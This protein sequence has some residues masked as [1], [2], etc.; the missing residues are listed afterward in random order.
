[1]KLLNRG[2]RWATRLVLGGLATAMLVTLWGAIPLLREPLAGVA[3]GSGH[4]YSY[5]TSWRSD[6]TSEP[7]PSLFFDCTFPLEGQ[8]LHLRL[9][10][11]DPMRNYWNGCTATY[12]GETFRCFS[13]MSVIGPLFA[14]IDPKDVG[15]SAERVAQLRRENLIN[16]L[17]A[18]DWLRLIQGGAWALALVAGLHR[19]RREVTPFTVVGGLTMAFFTYWAA[20]FSLFLYFSTL[21]VLD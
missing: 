18:L 12:R 20:L 4:S 15:I 19:L 5:I 21:G 13:G 2:S 11:T 9:K 8:P 14:L 17:Y 16:R 3:L 7:A 10:Y 6:C 1:M